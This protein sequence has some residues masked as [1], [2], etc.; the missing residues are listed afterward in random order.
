[1]N[2][3]NHYID[4]LTHIREEARE[5][6]DWKLSD[7]IRDYLDS[8]NVFC[9]DTADGQVVYHLPPPLL[10]REDA[11]KKVSNMNFKG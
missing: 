4:E 3:D 9:V 11:L 7:Q 8:K 2:F 1:M 10:S 6:K 5:Q